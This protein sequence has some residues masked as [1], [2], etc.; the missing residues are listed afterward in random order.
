VT[1]QSDGVHGVTTVAIV[2][3]HEAVRLGLRAACRD[4]G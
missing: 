1:E 2:D 3:D 4:A